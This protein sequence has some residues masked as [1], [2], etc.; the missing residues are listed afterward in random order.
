MPNSKSEDVQIVSVRLPR[1]LIQRLDR[2]LD[3]QHLHR[4]AKSSRNAAIRQAL[5]SWLDDQ[6]QR[7]GFLEPQRQ[8][9]QFQSAY[10]SLSKRREWVAI[11]RLRQLMPWSRE[12]F[13]AMV[14]TLRADHQVELE[15]AESSEMSEN[16][17]E[18]CY[19]VHGQLY[20]RLKWRQ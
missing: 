12:R 8:R 3:W 9:Q 2:Y 10:H 4:Q 6:E 20:H 14:E 7:S 19:E 18:S 5:D 11:D 13:D 1:G 16:A 15:R 17:I